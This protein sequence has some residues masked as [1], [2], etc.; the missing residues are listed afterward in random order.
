[1]KSTNGLEKKGNEEAGM[2]KTQLSLLYIGG[3]KAGNGTLRVMHSGQTRNHR[4]YVEDPLIKNDVNS[5]W[6]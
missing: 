2:M 5:L 4:K 6:Q 3:H 1:M